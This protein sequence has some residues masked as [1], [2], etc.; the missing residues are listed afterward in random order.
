MPGTVLSVDDDRDP[1]EG[2]RTRLTEQRARVRATC[3]RSKEARAHA[4]AAGD[5]AWA[6]LL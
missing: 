2:L 5:R 4:S 6:I 3:L 1:V